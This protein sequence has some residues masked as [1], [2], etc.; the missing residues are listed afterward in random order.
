M[1]SKIQPKA[2]SKL[3]VTKQYTIIKRAELIQN[4]LK[5]ENNTKY[6]NELGCNQRKQQ[7]QKVFTQ[8]TFYSNKM[9]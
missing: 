3:N 5:V 8:V 4:V 9:H 2:G 7:Q 1:K 6:V